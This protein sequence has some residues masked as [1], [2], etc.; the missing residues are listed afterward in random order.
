MNALLCRVGADQSL[1]DSL[2][3]RATTNCF[4]FGKRTAIPM[5]RRGIWGGIR[6]RVLSPTEKQT[7]AR[8]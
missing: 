4:R 7:P 8:G 5:W 2:S 6:S 1:V 3:S